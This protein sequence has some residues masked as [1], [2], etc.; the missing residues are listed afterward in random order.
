MF[1]YFEGITCFTSVFRCTVQSTES[2][3]PWNSTKPKIVGRST[4]IRWNIADA[5]SPGTAGFLLNVPWIHTHSK[6]PFV[7]MCTKTDSPK[8]SR[9]VLVSNMR[10]NIWN[11]KRLS[12]LT[13]NIIKAGGRSSGLKSGWNF[14]LHMHS[15][16]LDK[17][18]CPISLPE[19]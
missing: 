15:H 13:Q 12:R 17:K 1:T 14:K 19:L 16:I 18:E 9:T 2:K 7:N 4:E 10:G 6:H 11:M 3:A 5:K 8:L